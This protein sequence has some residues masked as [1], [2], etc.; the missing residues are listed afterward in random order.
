MNNKNTTD[1]TYIDKM[2]QANKDEAD[3]LLSLWGRKDRRKIKSRRI[4]K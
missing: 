4:K 1:G 2:I 3:S